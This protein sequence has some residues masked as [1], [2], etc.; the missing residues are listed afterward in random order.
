[1][2]KEIAQTVGGKKIAWIL[3]ILAFF[4]VMAWYGS[5]HEAGERENQRVTADDSQAVAAEMPDQPAGTEV[6]AALYAPVYYFVSSMSLWNTP[7]S[8]TRSQSAVFGLLQADQSVAGQA[9]SFV[10]NLTNEN[11]RSGVLSHGDV[12]SQL[13]T[14]DRTSLVHQSSSVFVD[15]TAMGVEYAPY[16]IVGN[17]VAVLNFTG[18]NRLVFRSS[19]S[20]LFTKWGISKRFGAPTGCVSMA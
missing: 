5:R 14:T 15:V 19:D 9:S 18:L 12:N 13:A 7:T 6:A 3:A 17:R 10:I 8:A 20:S 4:A 2:S 1:M 16:A 11:P